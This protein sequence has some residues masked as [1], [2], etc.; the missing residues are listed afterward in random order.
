MRWPEIFFKAK[1]AKRPEGEAKPSETAAPAPLP[2][3]A[4]PEEGKTPPPGTRGAPPSLHEPPNKIFVSQINLPPAPAHSPASDL[5]VVEDMAE[6]D[7]LRELTRSGG[8]RLVKRDFP[9]LDPVADGASAASPPPLTRSGPTINLSGAPATNTVPP[10]PGVTIFRRRTKMADVARIV[11]PP[12]RDDG[13]AAPTRF[14]APP[15]DRNAVPGFS[16][17]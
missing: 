16:S 17:G 9:A 4:S 14:G 13:V 8:V 15:A 11:L 12:R 2:E 3:T 1:P 10:P 6:A 7:T 5:E